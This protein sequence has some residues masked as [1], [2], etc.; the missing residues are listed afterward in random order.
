MACINSFF[1]FSY[2]VFGSLRSPVVP[3]VAGAGVDV[4]PAASVG[5][6]SVFLDSVVSVLPA[7][8]AGGAAGFVEAEGVAAGVADMAN[9]GVPLCRHGI[10]F[11][12]DI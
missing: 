5:L 10:D 11:I 2:D 3:A 6:V 12:V 9:K 4:D 8:A 7:G 1:A